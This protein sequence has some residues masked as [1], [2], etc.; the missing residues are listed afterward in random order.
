M[1]IIENK[2]PCASVSYRIDPFEAFGCAGL[3]NHARR[4]PPKTAAPHQIRLR[5]RIANHYVL[6]WADNRGALEPS[7]RREIDSAKTKVVGRVGMKTEEVTV[8]AIAHQVTIELPL[9]ADSVIKALRLQA[10]AAEKVAGALIS[11]TN[12]RRS[13]PV[14]QRCA[15]IRVIQS[16]VAMARKVIVVV[17]GV[18]LHEQPDLLEVVHALDPFAF[19][20]RFR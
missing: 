1:A 14:G 10:W 11:V 7:L 3:V 18:E 20:L 5:H 15:A 6:R 19:C 2:D 8:E 4:R 17:I 12:D 13:P 9:P 16:R